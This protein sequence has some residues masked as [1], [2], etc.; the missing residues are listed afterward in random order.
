MIYSVAQMIAFVSSMFTLVP[1]DIILTG[2]AKGV[3]LVEPGSTLSASLATAQGE[4]LDEMKVEV[5][6]RQG[7]Y[8]WG[9]HWLE[10]L[11]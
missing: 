3:S 1:G 10:W 9:K 2:A 11:Q 7:G 5:I 4:I 6:T 8:E